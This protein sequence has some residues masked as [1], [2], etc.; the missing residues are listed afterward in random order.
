MAQGQHE[1]PCAAKAHSISSH[2]ATM[3][4]CSNTWPFPWTQTILR[5]L[6]SHPRSLPGSISLSSRWQSA[7]CPQP[8]CP[9]PRLSLCSQAISSAAAAYFPITSRLIREVL[10]AL[11]PS[12]GIPSSTQPQLGHLNPSPPPSTGGYNAHSHSGTQIPQPQIL[13][14]NRQDTPI[15]WIGCAYN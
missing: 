4:P 10:K 2:P 3:T 13:S 12:A 5:H 6:P 1:C 8:P 15:R 9:S 11:L 7:L 14:E